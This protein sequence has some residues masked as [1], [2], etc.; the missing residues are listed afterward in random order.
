MV[1]GWVRVKDLRDYLFS[2]DFPSRASS[3]K[4]LGHQDRF[5]VAQS[6]CL[7]EDQEGQIS[8]RAQ[9]LMCTGTQGLLNR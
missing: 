6:L 2:E 8:R 3:L 9:I 7:L 5:A 4:N 1:P